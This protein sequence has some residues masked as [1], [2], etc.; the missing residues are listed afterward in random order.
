M[1]NGFFEVSP[2]VEHAIQTGKPVVALESTLIAH[3]L[4]YPQNLEVASQM[5]KAVARS[6][7]VA[8]TV[9][10][11]D[12]VCKIG[13]L[14]SE[15]ERIA[16][17]ASS[18]LKLNACDIPYAVGK[19]LN[20]A[21]TVSATAWLAHLAKI[22]VFATGG[23]G[24]VHRDYI[25]AFDVSHDLATLS[26]IPMVVVASGAKSILDLPK[27]VEMLE[28]LG[29]LTL[30]YQTDT[31]PAFYSVS[32]GIH[33]EHRV[34]TP[35]EVA[36]IFHAKHYIG[37]DGSI[38]VANP[39]PLEDEIPASQIDPIIERALI[40]A[41][42]EGIEGKAVTPYLLKK[43]KELSQGKSLR[44]NISL[45][46]ENARLAGEIAHEVAQIV[47]EEKVPRIGF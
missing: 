34:E 3:G 5:E 38:L 32:S 17:D 6:G 14:E 23:I 41:R 8:A 1:Q 30:G 12:G 25:H 19:K 21:T 33:L 31:F 39:V 18:F 15:V 37:I 26:R 28:T 10:V 44:A 46:I 13:L 47:K 9:A 22:K 40:E 42:Q 24:G 36:Q 4:P 29:V 11:L 7:S 16:H 45:L 20:G 35:R 43:V 27:T 2:F